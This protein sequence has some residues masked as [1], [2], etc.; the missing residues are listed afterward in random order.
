MLFINPEHLNVK[1]FPDASIMA[2][3]AAGFQCVL[4]AIIKE[5][6]GLTIGKTYRRTKERA[7]FQIVLK[8]R[9]HMFP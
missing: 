5:S 1:I 7:A 4:I 6:G 3:P 8:R 9:P 2:S